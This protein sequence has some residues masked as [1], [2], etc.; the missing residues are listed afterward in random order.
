MDLVA[1]Q[2][3]E[4]SQIGDPTRAP[5]IGRQILNHWTAWEAPSH[6]ALKLFPHVEDEDKDSFI[7]G[8]EPEMK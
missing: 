8:C 7:K 3:V 5:C 6:L 1:L 2:H 4:S